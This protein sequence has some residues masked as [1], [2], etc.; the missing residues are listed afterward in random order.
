MSEVKE[1]ARIFP[2][3]TSLSPID[4]HAYFGEPDLFTPKYEEAH[5]SVTFTW[6]IDT[7]YKLKDAWER[8]AIRVKI[9]GVAISGESDQPFKA[10]MYLKKDVTITS[11]GCPNNCSFCLVRRGLI[12]FDDFP[13]GNIINDNNILA[14]SDKHLSLV[15]EMLKNQKQIEFK[16]GLEASR[17]TSKIAEKLRSLKIKTLWLACDTDSALKPLK[18]A[19]E[20]LNK[21]GFTRSHIYCYALIGK[22]EERL[23]EIFNIGA[24]PFAQLY[25][26]PEKK[27]R[28]YTP[29]AKAFQR[30]WCRPAAYRT[31]MKTFT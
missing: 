13:E 24:M 1:I 2:S 14:C 28:E 10:G 9:G 26:P 4:E 12:E 31:V 5:I 27:K 29:Q 7:A 18:K 3:K 11:R 23:R 17:I 20:I 22:E 15:F 19:V 8:N 6:D 30:T 16:G 21:A 25:L